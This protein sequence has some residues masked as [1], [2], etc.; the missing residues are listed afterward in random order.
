MTNQSLMIESGLLEGNINRMMV[1]KDVE[2]LC[3]MYQWAVRRTTTIFVERFKELEG[4][5]ET[6]NDSVTR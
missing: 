5:N 1:T 3:Y 4:L 2:E 6:H